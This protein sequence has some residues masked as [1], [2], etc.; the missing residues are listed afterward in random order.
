VL[1]EIKYTLLLTIVPPLVASI[2]W[3]IRL[4]CRI[5]HIGKE[6]ALR[7]RGEKRNFIC[8]FWHGRLLMMSFAYEGTVADRK[9]LVS[10]HRDGEFITRIIRYFG[11]GSIRGSH[12]KE[13]SVSGVREIIR[14]LKKGVTVAITPD[15]PK[16]PRYRVKEGIIE[17]ARAT[18]DVILP[19]T[20]SASKKKRFL[21]GIAS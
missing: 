4:T 11:I 5:E 12:R 6:E 8:C 2:L 16:G 21:P 3:C 13:G 19:V 15:G 20:Y 7:G 17:L 18:G 10:R 9:V 14:D 1:K